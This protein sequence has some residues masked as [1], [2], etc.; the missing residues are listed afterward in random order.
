MKLQIGIIGLGKFGLKL[1]KTL[2]DLG[3]EV[4]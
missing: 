3:H 1:G 2:V 4:L